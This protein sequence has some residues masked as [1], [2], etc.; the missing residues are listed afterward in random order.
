MDCSYMLQV[1][2]SKLINISSLKIQ[3]ETQIVL[4]CSLES[5][6]LA[7]FLRAIVKTAIVDSI[8]MSL[9]RLVPESNQ[10]NIVQLWKSLP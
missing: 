5:I 3:L 6:C 4:L 7:F 8:A 9:L 2:V 10:L 1:R